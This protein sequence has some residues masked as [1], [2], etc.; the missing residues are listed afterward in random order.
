MYIQLLQK[1]PTTYWKSLAPILKRSTN[2]RECAFFQKNSISKFNNKYFKKL[3]VAIMRIF[4]HW[5]YGTIYW[6]N[7][8]QTHLLYSSW[9]FVLNRLKHSCCKIGMYLYLDFMFW[10]CNS[11]YVQSLYLWQYCHN[12]LL[13]ICGWVIETDF[14][15]KIL[16]IYGNQI[17]TTLHNLSLW[18][19][20]NI[21]WPYCGM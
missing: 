20:V 11:T 18:F 12:I 2:T 16:D 21:Q 10:I 8:I 1:F 13:D 4:A 5:S 7:G 6:S 3:T 14:S 15:S 19:F 17:K 9:L